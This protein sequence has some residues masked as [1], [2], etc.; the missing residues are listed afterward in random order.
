M[1]EPTIALLDDAHG[2]VREQLAAAWQLHIDRIQEV[3]AAQWPDDIERIFTEAMSALAAK[4]EA[5]YSR[6]AVESR[7]AAHRELAEKLN[8]AVRR[9]RHF[10]GNSQWGDALVEATQGFCDRAAL[11]TIESCMLHL[12]VAL[13]LTSA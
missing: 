5:Q 3:V 13:N 11:F 12:E 7:A 10:E 6:Q 4:L 2:T 9:L 1:N 8:Q